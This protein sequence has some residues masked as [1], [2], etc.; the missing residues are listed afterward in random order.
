MWGGGLRARRHRG[1]RGCSSPASLLGG[2]QG[3]N[4]ALRHKAHGLGGGGR[5]KG[6]EVRGEGLDKGHTTYLGLWPFLRVIHPGPVAP[7]LALNNLARAIGVRMIIYT[8]GALGIST[9]LELASLLELCTPAA[10]SHPVGRVTPLPSPPLSTAHPLQ[11]FTQQAVSPPFPPLPSPVNRTPATG[12]YPA[13]RVT[14]W[15]EGAA[16]PLHPG[17]SNPAAA[18]AAPSGVGEGEQ[19]R[20]GEQYPSMCSKGRSCNSQRASER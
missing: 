17:H 20:E 11:G 5:K 7:R 14:L 13:G 4:N 8:E 12:F 19:Q 18:P 3:I 16:S 6:P 9:R 2:S 15:A 1:G 10:G